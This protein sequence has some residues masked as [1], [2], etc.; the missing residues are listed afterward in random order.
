MKTQ[1]RSLAYSIQK[2]LKAREL[3]LRKKEDREILKKLE[4]FERRPV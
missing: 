1:K 4:K 2:L 3:D